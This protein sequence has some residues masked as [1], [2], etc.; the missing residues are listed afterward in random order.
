MDNLGEEEGKNYF[1]KKCDF[2]VSGII[3]EFS[4]ECFQ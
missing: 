3:M 2:K 1:R 4:R